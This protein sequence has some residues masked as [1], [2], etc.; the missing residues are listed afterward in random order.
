MPS[1][2]SARLT[3]LYCSMFFGRRDHR[4]NDQAQKIRL[5][6]FMTINP[7]NSRPSSRSIRSRR[8]RDAD[9]GDQDSITGSTSFDGRSSR[10]SQISKRSSCS[11]Y[12]RP[13]GGNQCFVSW[14]VFD[15]IK[16]GDESSRFEFSHQSFAFLP[17]FSFSPL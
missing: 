9:G 13:R 4:S 2:E 8:G 17:V 11:I 15:G 7:E 16:T 14:R 1:R 10:Y 5:L 3:A 6:T 12:R